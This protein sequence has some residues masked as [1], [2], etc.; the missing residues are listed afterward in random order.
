[1]KLY[2]ARTRDKYAY[3]HVQVNLQN[4]NK[5]ICNKRINLIMMKAKTNILENFRHK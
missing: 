4:S 1:M 3:V 2:S 5:N